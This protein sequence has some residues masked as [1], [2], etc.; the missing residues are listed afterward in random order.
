MRYSVIAGLLIF[1]L[2]I[3]VVRAQLPQGFIQ[4]KVA[5]GLDPT[6]IAQSDD[7]RN[8]VA[9]KKGTVRVIKNGVL[10]PDPFISLAVDNI[11]ERGL[12]GIVMDPDFGNNQYFYLYYA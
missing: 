9:E 12:A 11:D 4:T 8:F 5:D 10:L 1:V 7:G 6:R 2:S 3:G